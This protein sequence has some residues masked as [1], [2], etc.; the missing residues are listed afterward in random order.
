MT[1]M[2]G[3]NQEQNHPSRFLHE[4]SVGATYDQWC[5]RQH[6][7]PLRMFTKITRYDAPAGTQEDSN[8]L[9][10]RTT[11]DTGE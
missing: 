2:M 8:T 1:S 10:E 11:T 6:S 3:T 4:V 7:D 9:S 5:Q